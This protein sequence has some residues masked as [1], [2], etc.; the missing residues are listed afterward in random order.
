MMATSKAGYVWPK[1]SAVV[2]QGGIG[3]K[4]NSLC[5]CVGAQITYPERPKKRYDEQVSHRGMEV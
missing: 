1:S 2:V 5:V 3:L 4:I